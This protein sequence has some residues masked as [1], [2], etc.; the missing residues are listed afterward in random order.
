MS[1]LPSERK[2]VVAPPANSA[3]APVPL[4]LAERRSTLS[5][6]V[7]AV[8][9]AQGGG[10]AHQFAVQRRISERAEDLEEGAAE[11]GDEDDPTAEDY[12]DA[13]TSPQRRRKQ[14]AAQMKEE[15][16]DVEGLQAS[17]R[18]AS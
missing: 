10:R 2:R 6:D 1:D 12:E 13:L 14:I 11:M 18:V 4:G 16:R 17:V 8:A 5:D 9:N 15:L 7:E 3:L